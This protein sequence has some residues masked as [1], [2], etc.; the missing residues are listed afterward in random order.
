MLAG[1]FAALSV[2]EGVQTLDGGSLF[3]ERADVQDLRATPLLE[4][5]VA[6][7]SQR[8]QL[9]LLSQSGTALAH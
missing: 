7:L 6:K 8:G 3:G 4:F 5:L 9:F 2:D 1:E